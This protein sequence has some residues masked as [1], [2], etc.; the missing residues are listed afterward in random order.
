MKKSRQFYYGQITICS[1]FILTSLLLFIK[2]GIEWWTGNPNGFEN[3][4]TICWF[5]TMILTSVITLNYVKD[6]E[7]QFGKSNG[8]KK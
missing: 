4:T 1:A 6:Y 5:G 2:G 7:K 3:A 8:G